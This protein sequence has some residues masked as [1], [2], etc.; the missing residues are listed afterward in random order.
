[1]TDRQRQ[2]KV[3]HDD[4]LLIV[5]GIHDALR[6]I[7][8]GRGGFASGHES[9]GGETS[10]ITERLALLTP[11]QAERDLKDLERFMT[12]AEKFLRPAAGIVL[13]W[14]TWNTPGNIRA[15]L[16]AIDQN[17]WCTN[18]VHLGYKNPRARDSRECDYCA[19]FRRDY[20]R[21]CPKDVLDVRAARGGRIYV[22]DI[23]R[24]LA[25]LDAEAKEARKAAREA[26]KANKPDAA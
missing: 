12:A 22:Q 13:R 17:L 16:S 7:N 5:A 10:S 25:R 4:A 2:A 9:S 19:T 24:I 3:M 1:M 6:N 15:R 11:D 21:D 23:Q 14:A 20:K 18:C 26:A 8:T